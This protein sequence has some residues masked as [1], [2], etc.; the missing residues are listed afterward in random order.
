MAFYYSSLNG[1]SV[2]AT[3]RLVIYM[4]IVLTSRWLLVK[5]IDSVRHVFSSS[6]VNFSRAC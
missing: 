5:I 6:V 1:A 4:P 3:L 2:F